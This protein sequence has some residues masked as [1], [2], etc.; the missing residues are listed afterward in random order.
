MIKYGNGLFDKLSFFIFAIMNSFPR[1]IRS[2]IEVVEKFISRFKLI[3]KG[4]TVNING[5]KYVLVDDESFHI[6]TPRFESW[7]WNYLKPE[8]GDVFLDVGAHVGKYA[9]QVAKIVGEKGTVI[10]IEPMPEN[11]DALT[12]NIKLN[13][14][15]NVIPLN[16]AA[17]NRECDVKLFIGD[18]GGRNSLKYNMGLGHV[19]VKAKPLD[20]VLEELNVNRVDWIK[21]DVE[22]AEYEVLQGLEKTLKENGSKLIVEVKDENKNKVLGFMEKLNYAAHP[23]NN[24]YYYFKPHFCY[25]LTPK[26]D[27]NFLSPE[28]DEKLVSYPRIGHIMTDYP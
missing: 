7:M 4:I 18:K 14:L 26:M 11:Y 22:G 21:I 5:T 24:E 13:G 2:K 9:L 27:G 1:T 15:R 12:R 28:L 20:T 23:I 16:I 6:V 8:E 25:T 10:A 19:E 3:R 17:W